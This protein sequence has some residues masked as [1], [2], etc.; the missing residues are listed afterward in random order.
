[1]LRHQQAVAA[2]LHSAS[3]LLEAMELQPQEERGRQMQILQAALIPLGLTVVVV[4]AQEQMEALQL[5]A[6]DM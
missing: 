6:L 3:Q 2:V 4:L 5:V 1:M